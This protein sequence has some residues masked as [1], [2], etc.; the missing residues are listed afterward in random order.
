MLARNLCAADGVALQACLVNERT[1]KI[2]RGTLKH[3]A[4]TRQLQRL[5]SDTSVAEIRHFIG[6]GL[7]VARCKLNRDGGD[8]PAAA[9]QGR[10]SVGKIQCGGRQSLHLTGCI[11]HTHTG[12]N[13]GHF[14]IIGAG[15]HIN[16][17]TNTAGN[18]HGKLQPAQSKRCRPARR[19]SQRNAAAKGYTIVVDDDVVKHIA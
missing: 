11:H 13:L 19:H 5:L 18:A 6:N 3:A 14:T 9:L 1:G 16:C 8:D 10:V 2:S 17:A 4:G 15:V 12:H 7:L